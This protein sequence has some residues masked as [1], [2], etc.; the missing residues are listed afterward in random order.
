MYYA[1]KFEAEVHSVLVPMAMLSL[2]VL[3]AAAM[4]YF[5]F[6]K[7]IQLYLDG[8]KKEAMDLLLK[9]ILVF[10]GITFSIFTAIFF[11]F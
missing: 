7:P 10:A 9:T 8:E 6:S 4:A 11:L 2:F 3:S 5:F 1:P